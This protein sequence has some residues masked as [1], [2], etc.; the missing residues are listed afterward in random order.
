MT[1]VGSRTSVSLNAFQYQREYIRG[2]RPDEDGLGVSL[3]TT[4]QVASNLSADF[5][6]S[7][8][9]YDR[10]AEPIGEVVVPTSNDTDVQAIF[11]LN[12]E[13]GSK[14]TLSGEA[15]YLTRSGDSD[16]DGWWLALRGR[17]TP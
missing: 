14:L 10:S 2:P 17:W 1:A 6:L 11:R 9:E 15:G 4:R 3:G 7:Y 12:R 13:M 8:S 5:T 16:Y